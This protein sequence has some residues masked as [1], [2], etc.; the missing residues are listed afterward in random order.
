[1][2]EEFDFL[3]ELSVANGE[4]KTTW[5]SRIA[6][7]FRHIVTASRCVAPSY[8]LDATHVTMSNDPVVHTINAPYEYVVKRWRE[9]LEEK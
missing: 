5:G 7:D 2:I 1:M 9:A 4:G 8:G 6:L 3:H